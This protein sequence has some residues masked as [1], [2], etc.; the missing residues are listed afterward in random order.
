MTLPSCVSIVCYFYTHSLCHYND[1]EKEDFIYV[2]ILQGIVFLI[3]LIVTYYTTIL[4]NE[5]LTFRLFPPFCCCHL[6]AYWRHSQRYIFIPNAFL[7]FLL[8]FT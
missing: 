3:L 7:A 1:Y 5:I 4:S 8:D 6:S 2:Y